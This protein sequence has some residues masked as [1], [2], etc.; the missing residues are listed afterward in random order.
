[1]EKYIY[2]EATKDAV[3]AMEPKQTVIVEDLQEG[4]NKKRTVYLG[5]WK[6]RRHAFAVYQAN[7]DMKTSR[8]DKIR[9]FRLLKLHRLLDELR[10]PGYNAKTVYYTVTK[11]EVSN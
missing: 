11:E 8:K 10:V 6:D 4:K 9:R 1:M 2:T 7:N 5:N 3:K